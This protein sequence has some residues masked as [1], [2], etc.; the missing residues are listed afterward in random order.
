MQHVP[1]SCFLLLL[2]GIASISLAA[3][4]SSPVDPAGTQGTG[5]AAS[6]GSGGTGGTGAVDTSPP[7]WNRAVTPP[8]DGEAAT[9]R[10][11]CDYAKGALPAETQGSSAP[12]GKDIPI[13][14]IVVMMMENR[15]FDHYF[16]GAAKA[17]LTD[18]EVA[19]SNFANLD[20]D[21]K[22]IPIFRDNTYCFV[23]TAHG[24][25]SV[26][27]QI[28]GGKMDGFVTSN[29]ASHEMPIP[30]MPLDMLLGNRG[31]GY[32]EEADIPFMYWVAKTFAIGDH[33]HCSVPAA[34][35][36][37]RM[38]LYAASSF[39]RGGNDFPENVAATLFDH[40]DVRGIP[41]RIYRSS[42]P[43]YAIFADR[44][45]KILADPDKITDIAQFYTDAAAGKLP[46]VVFVD[47]EF[48]IDGDDALT[49]DDEH[50]PAIMEY[51]QRTMAR[52]AD[53]LTRSPQWKRS[54]MFV[55]YD[56]HGGLYDHV[57]PPKACPPDDRPSDR[58]GPGEGFDMLGVRV[59]FL[60]ISPFAKKRFV[61]HKVYDHTSITRFIEARFTLPALSGRDANAEA[62]W[63]MFDFAGAPNLVPATVPI[64]TVDPAKASACKTLWGK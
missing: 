47:A 61:G 34:T 7:E 2:T 62:P 29:D 50:P 36:P 32:Y 25:S 52:V 5:G 35:W 38:Y 21:G 24:W 12:M 30:G 15:S 53:A 48:S 51:G 39:G 8:P 23:D 57:P 27:K 45:V 44:I 43:C 1:R 22:S 18:I 41:W 46:P 19:P 11:A 54:A 64:P 10:S 9:K 49:Q 3:C 55:T 6:S 28:N 20:P 26:H 37:N 40:L 14:T 63:E 33:Y 16:Q 58:A 17:G 60:V 31:M 13:D 56:E 42:T 4:S 59:P